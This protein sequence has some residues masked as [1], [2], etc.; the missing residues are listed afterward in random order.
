M[1]VVGNGR[2]C[3]DGLK[4]FHCTWQLLVSEWVLVEQVQVALGSIPGGATF[5][6]KPLLFQR[7]TDGGGLDCVVH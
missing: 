5:P 7:S 6:F 1:W 4:G 3:K 2:F